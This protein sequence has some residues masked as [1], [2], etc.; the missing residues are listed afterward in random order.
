[1][2]RKIQRK[3]GKYGEE[4]DTCV[5]SC[6]GDAAGDCGTSCGTDAGAECN[7]QAELLGNDSYLLG[8]CLWKCEHGSC[9]HDDETVERRRLFEYLDR[10][11]NLSSQPE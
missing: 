8:N 10:K 5:V 11:W 6:A 2:Q 7:A 4:T 1:M 3:G 9:F